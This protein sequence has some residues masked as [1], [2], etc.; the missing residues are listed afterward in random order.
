MAATLLN[1]KD[2]TAIMQRLSSLSENSSRQWGTMTPAE[3]CWHCRQ[4][5]EFVLQPAAHTKIING[6]LRFFPFNWMVI[7]VMPWPKGSPT[8]PAMDA[9]KAHQ[10]VETFEKEKQMLTNKLQEV[11]TLPSISGV[12]PL[13]GDL[14]TKYWGRLIWKHLDHHLRQF[15]H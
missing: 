3:M 12:H 6:P 4:Q 7:Y 8:A 10:A 5:L 9:K 14:N 2:Y 1:A 15:N 13:F 11:I